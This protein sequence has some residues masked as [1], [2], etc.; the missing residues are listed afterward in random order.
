M[1]RTDRRSDQR[2]DQRQIPIVLIVVAVL[3][4]IARFTYSPPEKEKGAIDW[5]SPEAGAVL[6]RDSGK[7]LLLFFTAEWCGPCHMLE[8]QVFADAATAARISE[9]F[10]P[11]RITDR[12]REEGRNTPR[13]AEL[14]TRY[15]VRGFPTVVFTDGGGAEHARMEG[16]QG[17]EEFVRVMERVR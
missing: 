14:K 9:R 8:D 13:V 1:A 12:M 7:P 6:A 2:T 10:V 11:V 15:S 16:F 5:V 3:L 4:L 17:R